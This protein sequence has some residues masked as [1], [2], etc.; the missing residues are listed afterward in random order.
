M[1]ED[2]DVNVKDEE[3]EADREGMYL[4]VQSGYSPFGAVDLSERLAKL[5]DEYV[6]HAQSPQEQLSQLAMQSLNGYFRS[7]PLPS[8]APRPSQRHHRAG[9]LG[10]PHRAKTFSRRIRSPQRRVREI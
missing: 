2:V 9:T 4:P 6:I 10:I 7:H 5:L 3:F 8:E 1:C